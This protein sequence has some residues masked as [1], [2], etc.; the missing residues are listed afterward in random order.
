[1]ETSTRSRVQD[2][3]AAT[4][5]ALDKAIRQA[6]LSAQ[7]RPRP[8][9]RQPAFW[10]SSL[11]LCRRRTGMDLLGFEREEP[12]PRTLESQDWGNV[13]HREYYARLQRLLPWGF[14][15]VGEPDSQY[16]RIEVPGVEAPIRGRYDAML[17]AS[18]EAIAA[19]NEG[20]LPGDLLPTEEVR[21]ILDIK[22]TTSYTVREVSATGSPA[23]Q[24]EAE[25]ICY[26][27]ATGLPFG[28]VLYHD[29]QSSLRAPA[30][31][32]YSKQAWQRIEEWV[33]D[34]WE[35]V[36]AG[37]VP[38]R[39]HDPDAGGFPCAWCPHRTACTQIGP[40]DGASPAPPQQLHIPGFSEQDQLATRARELVDTIIRTESAARAALESVAPLRNELEAILQ[41]IG[42]VDTELGSATITSSTEWDLDLLRVR[43]AELGKLQDVLEISTARV[44][45]LIEAGDLPATL[46]ADARRTTPGRLRITPSR[47]SHGS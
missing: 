21:F 22:A 14:R 37:L 2:V 17:E 6:V 1:M 5:A 8:A 35:H 32:V 27:H 33:R 44:R 4:A 46:L 38:P 28:I 10:P 9:R 13:F 41:R 15:L 40:G 23:P 3:A 29:R 45:Q 18:A 24:D 20:A 36:S 16:V 7:Q 34:V 43:L 26:L 39:D 25:M 30:P 42:R 31:V 11:M 47:T 19:L 12:D